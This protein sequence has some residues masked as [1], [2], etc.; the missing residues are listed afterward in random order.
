MILNWLLEHQDQNF[1]VS[2]IIGSDFADN[3]LRVVR[4][5]IRN[6][7]KMIVKLYDSYDS[8]YTTRNI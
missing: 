1:K 3:A 8:K 2:N 5:V 4:F 6:S 7:D